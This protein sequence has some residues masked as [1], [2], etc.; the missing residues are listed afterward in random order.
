MIHF[1]AC[2]LR[3]QLFLRVQLSKNMSKVILP[4]FGFNCAPGLA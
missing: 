3:V 2:G 1:V 4:S